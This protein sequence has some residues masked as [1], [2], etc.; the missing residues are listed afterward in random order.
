[1]SKYLFVAAND[2]PHWGGSEILW[3]QAA[4]KLARRGNE[5][6]VS[7]PEFTRT[8]PQLEG[9]RSSGCRM[10]YRRGFPPFL[11]RWG[12]RVSLLPDYK[13]FHLRSAAY[14]ADL[15]VISQ[16]GNTDGIDWMEEA[17]TGDFKYAIIAQGALPFWWPDDDFSDRLAKVYE[18]AGGAYFV[19]QA[20]LQLSRLQFGSPLQNAKVVRNPFNVHYDTAFSWPAD[21]AECIRLACVARVEIQKGYDLLLQVLDR[22]HWRERRIRISVVGKGPNER[23]LRRLAAQLGLTN[24]EFAGHQNEIEGVWSKHHALVLPTRFEGMPLVVVEAMLCGRPCI[25][26]DVGGNRELIRDGVNGFLAKAPT[27]ELLD[28]AMNRAW[29]NRHRLREMGC[30]AAK[31]VREWVSPDPAE[32][33]ARELEKLVGA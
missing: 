17:R 18:N 24:I 11:Y 4:E 13:Q 6:R 10:F 5:V 22:P 30:Q 12:R 8:I 23:G 29:E 26:T 15:V 7:V 32:D 31:D 14:G 27:V 21:D 19:S 2:Y 16:G 33:F 1:M 9:L 28:E 20:I 3:S 25:A